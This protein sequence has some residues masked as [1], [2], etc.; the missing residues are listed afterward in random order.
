M[1]ETKPPQSEQKT[2][3]NGRP[4][5]EFGQTLV[6]TET[7]KKFIAARD[8]ISTN[9]AWGSKNE[10]FSD[11]GVEI[12]EKRGLLD[13]TKPFG[14]YLSSDGKSVTGWKGNKLGTVVHSSTSKTGFHRSELTHISVIDVH[15]NKW[16]GKGSGKGM[17]ITIRPSLAKKLTKAEEL[18][19]A[20]IRARH[21][22][23][24]HSKDASRAAAPGR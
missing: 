12:R 10:I 23:E 18:A 4:V 5:I 19:A 17:A 8:G 1:T 21:V 7:G 24:S 6:C 22:I 11:E 9:Y 13:R 2:D 20:V 3:V 16:H 15:G 14:C